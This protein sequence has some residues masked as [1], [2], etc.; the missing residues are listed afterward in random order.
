L[1]DTAWLSTDSDEAEAEGKKLVIGAWKRRRLESVLLEAG[2]FGLVTIDG[3][4]KG[5]EIVMR[6]AKPSERNTNEE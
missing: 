1:C 4:L 6:T 3:I 2:M 5:V